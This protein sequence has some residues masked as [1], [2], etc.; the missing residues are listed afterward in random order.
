[1]RTRSDVA[2]GDGED[3][4]S[5]DVVMAAQGT[6]HCPMPLQPCACAGQSEAWVHGTVQKPPPLAGKSQQSIEVQSELLAQ[7]APNVPAAAS[8]GFASP[9]PPPS[10]QPL[11]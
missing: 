5:D 7:L 9:R 2:D 10:P 8:R 4:G 6:L 11:Q 1:M 3:A